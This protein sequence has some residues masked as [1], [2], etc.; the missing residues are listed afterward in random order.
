[1]HLARLYLN[2]Y[3]MPS[4]GQL[5]PPSTSARQKAAKKTKAHSELGFRD[6]YSVGA[7]SGFPNPPRRRRRPRPRDLN[8]A[9][10][11][12]RPVSACRPI[13]VNFAAPLEPLRSM[14]DRR[15]RRKFEQ[16]AAKETKVHSGLGF[17]VKPSATL[18]FFDRPRSRRRP[19]PRDLK[20]CSQMQPPRIGMSANRR[21]FCCA[22]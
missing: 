12:S 19:R 20:W 2:Y 13:G 21:Q 18:R 22:A 14:L 17:R 9:A 7:F 5:E 15:Q 1:M 16:K 11:C 4:K 10:K 3:C 6:G 8:S